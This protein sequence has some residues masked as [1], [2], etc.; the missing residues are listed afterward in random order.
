MNTQYSFQKSFGRDITF[1]SVS[2]VTPNLDVEVLSVEDKIT[3]PDL[4]IILR[5]DRISREV[6]RQWCFQARVRHNG[7]EMNIPAYPIGADGFGS[8]LNCNIRTA[9][10]ST[11]IKWKQYK[12]RRH[13]NVTFSYMQF[14]TLLSQDIISIKGGNWLIV[15]FGT[16]NDYMAMADSLRG[17]YSTI[18]YYLPRTMESAMV[19]TTDH[20]ISNGITDTL[21]SLYGA[22]DICHLWRHYCRHGHRPPVRQSCTRCALFNSC[23]PKRSRWHEVC[24]RHKPIDK[25][26][27]PTDKGNKYNIY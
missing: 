26:G 11:L 8:L 14:L 22:H 10:T 4:F 3:D 15:G 13:L 21:P 6:L 25:D 18:T 1:E 5:P 7:V 17:K 23:N 16:E 24:R 12:E 20:T 27:K 9:T 19:F 2:P